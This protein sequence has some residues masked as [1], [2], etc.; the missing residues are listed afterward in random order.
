MSGA[1]GLDWLAQQDLV[2]GAESSEF[3][4][5]PAGTLD[6]NFSDSDSQSTASCHYSDSDIKAEANQ[7]MF[8]PEFDSLSSSYSDS[9]EDGLSSPIEGAVNNI[10]DVSDSDPGWSLALASPFSVATTAA[11]AAAASAHEGFSLRDTGHTVGHGGDSATRP[12]NS[13]S[14]GWD[15]FGGSHVPTANPAHH[16]ND[17]HIG[18]AQSNGGGA[19]ANHA[20]CSAAESP[21]PGGQTRSSRAQI[22]QALRCISRRTG[23]RKHRE[24]VWRWA[25]M[26]LNE[27]DLEFMPR[28]ANLSS[29]SGCVFR[30]DGIVR[31]ITPS[32]SEGC[33]SALDRWTNSGGIKGSTQWPNSS[34]QPPR[35]RC[36]YG[37]IDRMG[38]KTELPVVRYHMYSFIDSPSPK[39]SKPRRLFVVNL[40]PKLVAEGA[41][42]EASSAA[43]S[44]PAGVDGIVASLELKAS[45]TTDELDIEE[46]YNLLRLVTGPKP[47]LVTDSMQ[48]YE[49]PDVLNVSSHRHIYVE[50][51]TGKRRRDAR[52][53]SI[54]AAETQQQLFDKWMNSGGTKPACEKR[55]FVLHLSL[56][57]Q[58]IICRERQARLTAIERIKKLKPGLLVVVFPL[59]ASGR[60]SGFRQRLDRLYCGEAGG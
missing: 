36:Q 4:S 32:D 26:L 49:R 28:P 29:Q 41:G 55:I 30:E 47:D 16:N 9:G 60:W 20:C 43:F 48:K 6:W 59:Q 45:T 54:G 23:N 39:G 42:N 44:G 56:V 31:R 14:S 19:G 15:D 18:R 27:D 10:D 34:D 50:V 13:G 1:E 53:R 12:F 51:D 3:T 8:D 38:G 35:L 57:T 58:T 11:A 24:Q 2:L 22:E 5:A 33:P 25:E 17:N 21:Q 40:E 7:R 52:A 37:R 46:V